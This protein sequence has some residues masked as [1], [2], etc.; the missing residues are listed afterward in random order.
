MSEFIGHFHVVLV[1]LPIGILLLACAFQLLERKSG[2]SSL[3]PA[4]NIAFFIGMLSALLAVLTGYLLSRS[5][6][7]DEDLV[8]AHQWFAIS[9]ALVSIGMYFLN[10]KSG[11]SKT[12]TSVSILL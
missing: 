4:T 9:V 11:S 12:Q 1:H 10:R 7:Y 8:S 3:R 5:G 6:D 2:F